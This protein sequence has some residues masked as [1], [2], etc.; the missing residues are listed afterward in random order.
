MAHKYSNFAD[1]WY[2]CEANWA[3]A[4]QQRDW[5]NTN[6]AAAY[7]G[8][9][10]PVDK[11]HFGYL[12][13]AVYCLVKCFDELCDLQ[14]TAIDQSYFSEAIYWASTGGGGGGVTMDDIIN[15]MLAATFPQLTKF[16]G[17]VDAYRLALWNAPFN[18]EFYASLARGFQQW[19]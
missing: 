18:A 2:Y 7:S 5:A 6:Q 8:A 19:P 3:D 10:D 13:Y 15:E 16:I 1:A 4:K 12:C 9:S 11:T 17:I 14:A